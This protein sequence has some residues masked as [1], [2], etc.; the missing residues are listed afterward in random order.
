MVVYLT[1]EFKQKLS[2]DHGTQIGLMK[3]I[4]KMQTALLG[5]I[6]SRNKH[7]MVNFLVNHTLGLLL[8]VSNEFFLDFI[9]DNT[10]NFS[11][12][13]FI[14]GHGMHSIF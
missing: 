3:V 5:T 11:C 4:N 14:T 13:T 10:F 12:F 6:A 2:T 9:L 7:G 8:R 1:N